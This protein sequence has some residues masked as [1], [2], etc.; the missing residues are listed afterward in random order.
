MVCADERLGSRT[1]RAAFLIALAAS[2]ALGPAA[3]AQP[4]TAPTVEDCKDVCSAAANAT[5]SDAQQQKLRACVLA[6]R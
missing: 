5:L 6:R 2:L 1:L 4:Q 3:N